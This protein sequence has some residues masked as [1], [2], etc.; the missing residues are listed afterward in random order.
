MLRFTDITQ[1]QTPTQRK[2]DIENKY[3]LFGAMGTGSGVNGDG[4]TGWSL[5][6]VCG[7]RAT[8]WLEEKKNKIRQ[9]LIRRRR[10]T[11]LEKKKHKNTRKNEGFST[12]EGDSSLVK[13][14]VKSLISGWI[15]GVQGDWQNEAGD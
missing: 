7:L 4:L 8:G 12:T 3:L 1:L 9:E 6:V 11:T 15:A 14:G 2:K 13:L 10:I 5:Q